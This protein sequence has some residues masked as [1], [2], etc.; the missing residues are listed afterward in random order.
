[1]VDIVKYPKLLEQVRNILINKG[2][3][4]EK[5]FEDIMQYK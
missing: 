1:M 4:S 5:E 3:I 2:F